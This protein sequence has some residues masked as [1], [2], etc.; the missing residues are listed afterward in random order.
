MK[1]SE[2]TLPISYEEAKRYALV[3]DI[4]L[5]NRLSELYNQYGSDKLMPMPVALVDGR[6]MLCADLLTEVM[7]GGLLA[8][9][10]DAANKE[11]LLAS[12]EVIP[13]EQAITLIDIS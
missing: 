7:P 13:I 11:I 4:N 1:L 6:F 9:M 10:W 12:V 3:F 5:S 8:D 2:L